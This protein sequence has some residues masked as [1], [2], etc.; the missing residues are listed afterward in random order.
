MSIP[1][2]ADRTSGANQ[3]L[4]WGGVEIC[5]GTIK[6]II[7]DL[8]KSARQKIDQRSFCPQIGKLV[9]SQFKDL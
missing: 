8:I 7:L 4:T 6:P 9:D 3:T 1:A 2:M 5:G